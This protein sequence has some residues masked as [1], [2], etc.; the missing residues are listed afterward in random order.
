[1]NDQ[2][3]ILS[4]SEPTTS[5]LIAFGNADKWGR[6]PY[7]FQD[8]AYCKYWNIIPNNRL[9]TLRKY[10]VPVIDSLEFFESPGVDSLAPISTVVSYFG[11]DTGNSL[12]SLLSIVSGVNWKDID[13]NKINDVS[14]D[15]EDPS[16]F[17]DKLVHGSLGNLDANND[18]LNSLLASGCQIGKQSLSI[19]KYFA[20][21]TRVVLMAVLVH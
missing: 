1:M 2:S 10:P 19:A 12:S 18:F 4:V 5:D 9:L 6:T 3:D 8:F 16:D 14:A 11:G 17:V 21:F 13:G 7:S 20:L 15:D